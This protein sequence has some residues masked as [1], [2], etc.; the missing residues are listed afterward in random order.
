MIWQVCMLGC[1]RIGVFWRFSALAYWHIGRDWRISI[2]VVLGD[3][4]GI[5][6][7]AY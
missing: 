6:V 2:L 7:L 5:G 1:W 4:V 3:L